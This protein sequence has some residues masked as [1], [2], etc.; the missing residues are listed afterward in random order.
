[1]IQ[2][3]NFHQDHLHAQYVNEYRTAKNSSVLLAQKG[4]LISPPDKSF[5]SHADIFDYRVTQCIN[6]IFRMFEGQT[7]SEELDPLGTLGERIA[8]TKKPSLTREAAI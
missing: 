3:T 5:D 6:S 1:M 8:G 4:L 7:Y 2:N